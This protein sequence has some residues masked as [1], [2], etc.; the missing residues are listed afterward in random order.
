MHI[1]KEHVWKPMIPLDDFERW[2]RRQ[3]GSTTLVLLCLA[4][5]PLEE[6]IFVS[7]RSSKTLGVYETTWKKQLLKI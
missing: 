1:N 5:V 4:G 7:M 6:I 3:S 2:R